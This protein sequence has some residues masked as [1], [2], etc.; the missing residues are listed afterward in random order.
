MGQRRNHKGNQKL[1]SEMKMK[2]Q[3]VKT[4]NAAKTIEKNEQTPILK[5]P[6]NNLVFYFKKLFFKRAN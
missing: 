1:L 3:Y 2:I 6:Q 4:G 5:R